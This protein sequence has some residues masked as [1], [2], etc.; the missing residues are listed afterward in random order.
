MPSGV[1][2]WCD[3]LV[4]KIAIV[5]LFV[6]RQDIDDH[7]NTEQSGGQQVNDTGYPFPQIESVQPED[8]SEC[9]KQ[10]S[11]RVIVSSRRISSIRVTLHLWDQEEVDDPAYSQQPKREEPD[12]SGNGFSEI[13]SVRSKT[14]K[15]P[16]DITQCHVMCAMVGDGLMMY[17]FVCHVANRGG[18]NTRVYS[19][20]TPESCFQN[21]KVMGQ[22]LGDSRQKAIRGVRRARKSRK[23]A[24]TGNLGRQALI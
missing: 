20:F 13:E 11:D 17:S 8:T 15:E 5:D 6:E 24:L 18:R 7:A 12:N 16:S 2:A 3:F 14:S 19:E 22:E 1:I 23:I 21:S 4:V 9:E 10:P